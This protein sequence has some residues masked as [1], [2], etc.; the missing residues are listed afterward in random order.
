MAVIAP[1]HR[2]MSRDEIV[3]FTLDSFEALTEAD[4]ERYEDLTAIASLTVTWFA[5]SH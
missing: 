5:S 4:N 3:A 2:A 1:T